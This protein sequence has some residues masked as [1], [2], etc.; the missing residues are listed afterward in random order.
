MTL[1]YTEVE[2]KKKL[3]LDNCY[4]TVTLLTS[5]NTEVQMKY[6]PTIFADNELCTKLQN[7]E[8]LSLWAVD[9]TR[10][11]ANPLDGLADENEPPRQ[12]ITL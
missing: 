6:Q 3:F 4:P 12:F 9:T 2:K 11:V 5:P 7:G 8:S 1:D 10:L